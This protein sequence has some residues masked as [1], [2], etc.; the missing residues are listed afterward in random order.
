[1]VDR[2]HSKP[3]TEQT[4]CLLEFQGKYGSVKLVHLPTER[5]RSTVICHVKGVYTTDSLGVKGSLR[6]MSCIIRLYGSG[7]LGLPLTKLRS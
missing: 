7:L 1:M 4:K 2:G 5:G 6:V 3:E